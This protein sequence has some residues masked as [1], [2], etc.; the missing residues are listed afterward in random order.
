[1]SIGGEIMEEYYDKLIQKFLKKLEARLAKSDDEAYFA[2]WNI[3][4]EYKEHFRN[5][6][7][8]TA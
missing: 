8:Y 6:G 2:V 5:N 3:I 4:E 1:M 7:I